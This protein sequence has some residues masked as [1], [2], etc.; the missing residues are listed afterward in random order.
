MIRALAFSLAEKALLAYAGR[1][2]RALIPMTF[3]PARHKTLPVLKNP[4][5][6]ILAQQLAAGKSATDA[7]ELAGYRRSDTNGPALA[8]T[9]EIRGRVS[10]INREAFEQ[11]RAAVAVAVERTAITRQRL[12]EMADEIRTKAIEAGQLSAATAALK[13]LGVLSGIRIE[14]S[15]RGMPHEFAWLEKLTV[16][17]LQLLAAG[18]LDIASYHRDEEEASRSRL[19]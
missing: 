19:N 10:E 5:H 12:I 4:R 3:R 2:G 8:R 6:E 16:D 1:L 7:Y 14:R 15:E 11:Q 13:E 18:K 17:E 9:E